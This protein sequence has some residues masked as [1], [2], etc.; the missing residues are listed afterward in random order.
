MFAYA[1]AYSLVA[2]DT[3]VKVK[4]ATYDLGLEVIESVR[5]THGP[6]SNPDKLVFHFVLIA[7]IYRSKLKDQSK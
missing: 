2:C 5:K 1:L 7:V 6:L 4:V 3:Q